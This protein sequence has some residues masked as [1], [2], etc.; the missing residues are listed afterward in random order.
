MKQT[1]TQE[2][3][4]KQIDET[5]QKRIGE[6]WNE[7]LEMQLGRPPVLTNAETPEDEKAL[8]AEFAALCTEHGVGEEE[9][10]IIAF[11]YSV[12]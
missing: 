8:E 12:I 4:M 3:K 1:T 10:E 2:A 6:L 5:I 7:I 9:L 11:K